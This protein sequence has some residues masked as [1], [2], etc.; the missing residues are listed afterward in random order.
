MSP[1]LPCQLH[2]YHNEK[3]FILFYFISLGQ[4]GGM[5]E[6]K[7][8]TQIRLDKNKV[9]DLV[10]EKLVSHRVRQ[11]ILR[12]SRITTLSLLCQ[13]ILQAWFCCCC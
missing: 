8:I 5:S 12:P 4:G 10:K 1:T 11:S 7:N 6:G 2:Q 9:L 3:N 13:L